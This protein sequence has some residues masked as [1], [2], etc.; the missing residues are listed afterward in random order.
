MQMAGRHFS[1]EIYLPLVSYYAG[2]D[3]GGLFGLLRN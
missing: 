2:E 1:G 3:I